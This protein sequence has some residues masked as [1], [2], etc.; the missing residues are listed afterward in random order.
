MW[1]W[2]IFVC[3]VV[4]GILSPLVPSASIFAKLESSSCWRSVMTLPG[5]CAASPLSITDLNASQTSLFSSA[6]S[7]PSASAYVYC[8]LRFVLDPDSFG[9]AV[10]WRTLS[11]TIVF[12]P[13]SHIFVF[14]CSSFYTFTWSSRSNHDLRAVPG[15]RYL[16]DNSSPHATN[17]RSSSKDSTPLLDIRS[18]VNPNSSRLEMYDEENLG[19]VD[20]DQDSSDAVDPESSTS[21]TFFYWRRTLFSSGTDNVFL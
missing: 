9:F 2:W 8:Y 11:N 19:F 5:Y 12:T 6:S 16:H 20:H 10:S 21:W 18:S 4:F 13:L 3:T 15:G 1:R 17:S 14:I 7:R